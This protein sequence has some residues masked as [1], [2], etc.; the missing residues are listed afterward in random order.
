MCRGQVRGNC[1][2][3][4]IDVAWTKERLRSHKNASCEKVV[5]QEKKQWARLTSLK[6]QNN[7]SFVAVPDKE[8]GESSLQDTNDNDNNKQLFQSKFVDSCSSAEANKINDVVASFFF[9]ALYPS[10]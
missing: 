3:C 1:I 10:V 8:G 7:K 4:G 9:G 2:S 5:P 6:S